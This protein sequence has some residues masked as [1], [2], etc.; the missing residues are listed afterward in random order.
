M[1]FYLCVLL[2]LSL[3]GCSGSAVP[4]PLSEGE[5]DLQPDERPLATT[6]VY[7]CSGYEF[8]ARLGPGEMA[9][10]LPDQYVVLPQV[11]SA[12]G[13]LYEEGDVSFW[14]K[15]DDAML[16]VADEIYQD[17]QLQPQRV[18]WEDARRRGVDF[19]ATGNEPGWHLEIKSGKQMLFVYAYGMQRALVPNPTGE[20]ADSTRVYKGVSGGRELQVEI[21]EQACVDNMSGDQFPNRVVVT[22]DDTRY[23]GCGQDLEYPWEDQE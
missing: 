10:W 13:A 11:R 14:S 1:R 19:R 6:L 17:C 2:C 23:E 8:V 16:T 12:S 21:L 22:F 20:K 5:P 18:P 4:Q 9:L 3:Y 7:D 15:G